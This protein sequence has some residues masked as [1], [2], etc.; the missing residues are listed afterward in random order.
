MGF[1][2]TPLQSISQK[3]R[4]KPMPWMT[5]GAVQVLNE[6]NLDRDLDRYHNDVDHSDGTEEILRCAVYNL[7]SQLTELTKVLSA[8]TC[9]VPYYHSHTAEEA[10]VEDEEEDED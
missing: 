5:K 9:G 1:G 4:S 8:I 3:E 7:H 2:V 10:L 6:K